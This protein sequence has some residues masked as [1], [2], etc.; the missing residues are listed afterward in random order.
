MDRHAYAN[1]WC[2]ALAA[3]ATDF[4]KERATG[5]I[6]IACLAKQLNNVDRTNGDEQFAR[7]SRPTSLLLARY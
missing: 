5:R 1:D 7:G 2:D 4:Q 6:L 3:F